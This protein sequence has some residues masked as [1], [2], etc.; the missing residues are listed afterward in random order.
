M[1]TIPTSVTVVDGPHPDAAALAARVAALR[2]RFP[3]ALID[4]YLGLVPVAGANVLV[5]PGA[6]LAGDVQLGDDVSI[7][8]GAVLRGDLAPI[9]IGAG[10]NVQ[11]GAVLHVGDASPCFV[12]RD[13]V[14]GHRAILHG[15]RVEDACLIGMQATVLDDAVIGQGSVVGA[16]ALITSGTVIPPGSLV[17]GA[18]A[19]VVRKLTEADETFNRALAAKYV[20]LKENYRRDPSR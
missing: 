8:Y 4:R 1:A 5:A 13:V 10:S 3:G 7:W 12:G 2:A 19:R 18:P 6:A 16:C 9:V 17:L 15:C 14:V 11:D 20:R